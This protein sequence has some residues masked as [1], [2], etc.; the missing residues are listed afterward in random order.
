MRAHRLFFLI[1]RPPPESTLFP[2]TTLF[3]SILVHARHDRRRELDDGDRGAEPAPDG[4][5]LESD[6]ATADDDQALRDLGDAEGADIRKDA[7]FVELEEG[8]L[9][10]YGAGGDDD[11]LRLVSIDLI[12]GGGPPHLDHVVREQR[13]ASLRPRDLVLPE[14]ELQPLGVLAHHIVLPLQ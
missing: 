3:R 10:R 13:P 1:L 8:E 6:H 4:A 7:L 12:F 9:D 2:Y 5:E 14:Q 11:V